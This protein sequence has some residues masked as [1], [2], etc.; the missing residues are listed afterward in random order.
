MKLSPEAQQDV[1]QAYLVTM[2][3]RFKTEINRLTRGDMNDLL[4]A[5][6]A[7][8]SNLSFIMTYIYGLNWLQ[9]NI[10]SLFQEEVLAAF[11]NGPQAFLM[12]L[13]IQSDNTAEFID[14]YINYWQHYQGE[15]QLQ[16]QQILQ[17]LQDSNSPQELSSTI[18]ATWNSLHLFSKSF[19][20]GYKD[21]ARQEKDRYAGMLAEEDKERLKL[22]DQLPDVPSL[23]LFSK[24]GIIPAM[25]CPQTCRHC[26]F[27]FRPLMKNTDDPELLFQILNKLTTSILFTGGD[28]TKHLEHFY[29]AITNMQH[30]TTFAILLNG[31][32]ANSRKVTEEIIGNMAKAIRR[33]PITWPRAK[34]NLQISFDE[35]HQ[36]VIVNKQGQ[37]KERIPVV[38]IANIVEAAPKF[39]DEIQ[40]CLCHKQSHLNFSMDVFKKGVF[41]RLAKELGR[42]GHQIQILSTG[43]SA[44]LKR[45][46]HAPDIPAQVIKDA[47][48]VLS[49]Y[50][51]A[52]LMLTSSTIDAYGRAEM[53]ELHESVNE[54]DLLKQMLDG[55]GTSGETFDKDLMF[56]FN[57]WATLF[58]A[59]HMCLGNV[60]E[61]GIETI[62]QRQAKDP[63]SN[64]MFRFDI[65]LLDYYREHHNDLDSIVEKS[66]GPHHLFH[67]ITEDAAMRLHMTKRL[68]E[69]DF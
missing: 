22:V 67:C 4:E 39:I 47:T 34:V 13:I 30:V 50:P 28:L 29:N 45:N 24:L 43:P 35:F 1:H 42:R 41:A 60:F 12:Q 27:I 52:P 31:D 19:A 63:L 58:S 40:L 6:S 46:P 11:A 9:Q 10:H 57:G 55:K 59:V 5:E 68:I 15:P 26:M 69:S 37:L 8:A 61:D 25:G 17:L 21:I 49:K 33:R 66:T 53:M 65:R 18:E 7:D 3:Q 44:R 16:Q 32:F 51:Q 48:F 14:A 54:R 20:I 64:A 36:E 56:W 2:R 62:R 23:N 38:K